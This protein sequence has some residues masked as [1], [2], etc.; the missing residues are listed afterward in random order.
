MLGL[1]VEEIHMLRHF[2]VLF[3]LTFTRA[4]AVAA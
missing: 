4:M 1:S 3:T 2:G